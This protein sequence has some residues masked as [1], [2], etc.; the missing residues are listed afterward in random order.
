M[1]RK[2]AYILSMWSFAHGYNFHFE[3]VNTLDIEKAV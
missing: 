3:E 1:P 2:H